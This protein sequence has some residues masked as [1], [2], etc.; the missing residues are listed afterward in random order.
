MVTSGGTHYRGLRAAW[1]V[2][3][4]G[5]AGCFPEESSRPAIGQLAP[6]YAGAGLTG[7]TLA[8]ADIRGE[9]VLLNVWATWCAPCRVET[10][11]FQSLHEEFG[12]R[13]LR[14]V[15]VSVDVGGAQRAIE[16]F[17][18]EFGVEYT[19]LHDPQNRVMDIYSV[20]GLPTTYIIDAEGTIRLIRIGLVS[21]SDEEFLAT[22]EE[23]VS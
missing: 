10:P 5:V 19:I 7:D 16:R 18:D 6:P 1:L 20:P 3:L 4:V 2:L 11:F 14:V 23:L 8:L 15:G 12:P 9:P 21:E 22:L 13:G 17:K